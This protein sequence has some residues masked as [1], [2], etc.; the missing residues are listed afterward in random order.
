M[1]T[2]NMAIAFRISAALAAVCLISVSRLD[3]ATE[4]P[5]SDP[6]QDLVKRAQ[7]DFEARQYDQAI[8]ELSGALS[9]NPPARL[10]AEL[11]SKHASAY[12][13]EGEFPRAMADAE[14]A[15]Q[16][17]RNYFRGYQIRGRIFERQSKFDQA[18][19]EYDRAIKLQ[20]NFGVLHDNRGFLLAKKGDRAGAFEEFN[21]AVRLDPKSFETYSNRGAAY[22]ELGKFGEALADYGRAIRLAPQTPEAADVY[23]NRALV[24]DH[25]KDFAKA[26]ADLNE[27]VRLNPRAAA[28]YITR[29]EASLALHDYERA[30]VDLRKGSQLAQRN[31]RAL[32]GLAWVKAT[33]PE[34]SFR[35]GQNAVRLA[36]LACEVTKWQES[37]CIDTLA[38]AYAEVGEFDQAISYEKRALGGLLSWARPKAE[39][40]LALYREHKPYRDVVRPNSSDNAH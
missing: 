3:A 13:E 36:R 40:R 29:S 17:D 19:A 28:A 4:V 9:L 23:F 30:G 5:P 11:L 35:D 22:H 1:S 14:K 39:E 34:A 33:C 25:Q 24:Y 12:L 8:I 18:L 37:Y 7:T 32:S 38:A 31:P 21:K 6:L 10:A 20:P 16:R 27:A 26:I 15:I 2:P